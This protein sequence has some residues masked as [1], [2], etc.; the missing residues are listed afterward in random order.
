MRP[1]SVCDRRPQCSNVGAGIELPSGPT[2]AEFGCRQCHPWELVRAVRWV[3][4]HEN[5][6]LLI[7]YECH[8]VVVV[9]PTF[10]DV[11]RCFD[12]LVCSHEASV[13]CVWYV[14]YR[15]YCDQLFVFVD[16]GH[17]RLY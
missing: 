17:R 1:R 3:V 15:L 5:D 7:G 14:H 9:C 2:L 13:V 16:R 12:Y 6:S 11:E 8:I 4:S 10:P